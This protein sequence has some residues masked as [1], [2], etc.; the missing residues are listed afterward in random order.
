MTSEQSSPVRRTRPSKAGFD[1]EWRA[2]DLVTVDGDRISRG[3]IF[4]ESDLDAALVKFEELHPSAHPLENA[5]TRV[6]G[7]YNAHFAARE[8]D[9][10]IQML[11]EDHRSAGSSTGRK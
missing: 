2:I 11:A 6:Y 7:R 1:A 4:G 9:A 8:W 10:L 5:A 3:E